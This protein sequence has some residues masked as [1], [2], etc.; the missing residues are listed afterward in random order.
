MKYYFT[1]LLV[2]TNIILL[3][4]YLFAQYKTIIS[5]RIINPKEEAV[6]L[7]YSPHALSDEKI[8][9]Y[10]FLDE[11]NAFEFEIFIETPIEAE[12]S[13]LHEFTY[14]YIEPK[15][16]IEIEINTDSFDESIV[17]DGKKGFDNNNYMIRYFLRFK[18]FE[19]KGYFDIESLMYS[20]SVDKFVQVADS[21]KAEKL[22]FYKQ[23][24]ADLKLSKTFEIYALENILYED[25]RNRFRFYSY[26][27]YYNEPVPE[28]YFSF[29]DNISPNTA[30]PFLTTEYISFLYHYIPNGYLRMSENVI[31]YNNIKPSDL[32]YFTKKILIGQSSDYVCTVILSNL[33]E[34]S[35]TQTHTELFEDYLRTC[36]T[37]EFKSIIE[38]KY[39]E[40]LRSSSGS[41]SPNFN[42]INTNGDTALI[43][44]YFGKP[45]VV[46][47]WASWSRACVNE[48]AGIMLLQQQYINNDSLNF[49]LVSVDTEILEWKKAIDNFGIEGTHLLKD[50]DDNSDLTSLYNIDKIPYTLLIDKNGF[51]FKNPASLPSE[52]EKI[53]IEVEE[54]LMR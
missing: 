41:V 36:T 42:V 20:A 10:A 43:S 46:Y 47:F 4:H 44:S 35:L 38:K 15:D 37:K 3:P 25:A 29:L 24:Q 32:Y 52:I 17:Y 2:F 14:I 18:D 11:N 45:T 50:T 34:N 13:D 9:K 22:A 53:R 8:E 51:I 39:T 19:S 31:H 21:I 33:I 54:L 7:S 27:T 26:I 48:L 49:L 16:N 6:K 5:G 28:N 12:L 23:M 30:L 40:I 1:I